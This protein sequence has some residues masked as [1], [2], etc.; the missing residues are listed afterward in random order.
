M[1]PFYLLSLRLS[2]I[3]NIEVPIE[4]QFYKKTIK[5]DFDPSNYRIKAIYGENGSGKTAIITAVKIL[6]NI[7]SGDNYLFDS[8][9][10]RNLLELINKKTKAVLI[11]VEYFLNS[12]IIKN[13][14]KYRI[15]LK[16]EKDNRVH[17]ST[18]TLQVRKG[19]NSQNKYTA[20][21]KVEHGELVE[22]SNN[23]LFFEYKNATQNLLSQRSFASFALDFLKPNEKTISPEDIHVLYLFVFA[24]R[25]NVYIDQADDHRKYINDLILS[26]LKEKKPEEIYDSAVEA[27]LS[28][29]EYNDGVVPK[30]HFEN[31]K[32]GIARMCSFIQ[33]F[34]PNLK[35]ILIE[36]KDYNTGYKC[37]L[38]MEYTHYSIASEFE[39]NGIKKL[40]SLFGCLDAACRGFIVFIDELDSN[41]ND[42]YLNKIIEF[43]MK[44]GYGQLCFTAHNL[45]PMSILKSNKLSISFISNINTVHTW[46]RNGNQSPESAYRD[47]FIDDSPLNVDASDFLGI[48]G[49]SNE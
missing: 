23:P 2:G 31:Y 11:E 8:V 38:V 15:E 29:N 47:G 45:S 19:A 6:S 25:L 10:Q 41:I 36:T 37:N 33:M 7:I 39:S 28:L 3:K 42:I 40:M 30:E 49:G 16:I 1:M 17:I 20:V 46:V 22:H 9:T 4:F 27:D 43:F 32:M 26:E 12:D 35:N 13:C 34:K 18:E 21:Y 48:L 5:N 44:F 14:Y 24:F